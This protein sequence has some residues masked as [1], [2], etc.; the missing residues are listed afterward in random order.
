MTQ[1]RLAERRFVAGLGIA[2]APWREVADDAGLRAAAAELGTP[3]RLK[4]PIGGY[5][6]R[7][8][9]RIATP[10]EIPGALERLG[11]PPGTPLLVERELDFA[12]ELSVITAR[13]LD[14]ALAAFPI[15]R[16]RHDA[17]ILV[18]SAAPA[19]V[20]AAVAAAAQ[21]LG[22]RIAEALGAVG[23]VT[24]ELFLLRRRLAGRQ[25]ARAAR[26]Q[27]RPLDDRGRPHQPVRAARP[28]D[29]RA[30][31]GR[32]RR[33]RADG[34]G[35]PARDRPAPARPAWR[36]SRRRSPTRSSIS[37]STTSGGSSSAA[38]WGT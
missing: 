27:Q 35:Q 18:E 36:A 4:A 22:A 16:N 12:A 8:Q 26:P 32:P 38:R 28:G 2:T 9:V 31:A 17:G 33:A 5:D 37:T 15:A 14:G 30:A 13:A 21:A 24:A 11:R 19:P 7:S 6:G 34:D 25:R 10:D 1:D 29:L 3:L 20:G 23:L